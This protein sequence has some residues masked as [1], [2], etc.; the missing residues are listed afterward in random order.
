M[1]KLFRKNRQQWLVNNKFFKY[2]IYAIGEI[3]LV[4]IGILIA[5]QI[6]NWNGERKDLIKEQ[7]ILSQLKEE[8][9]ANL[10][11]LDEKMLMR[12]RIIQSSIEVLTYIDNPINT[13]FDSI[14]SKL[15]VIITD[16]TFDPIKNDLIISG[17]LR[18]IKNERLKRLLSNWSSDV[19]Q[20]Q[21]VE[22]EWQKMRTDMFVPFI[23]KLGISRDLTQDIWKNEDN[24]IYILDNETSSKLIIGKS[25]KTPKSQ[26]ILNNMELEGIVTNAITFNHVGNLQSI[27]L[28]NR[29][30]EILEILNKEI[31]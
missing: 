1:I 5:I 29:I 11:Q 22:I 28:R 14:I 2:L 26:E 13:N 7:Q 24:P 18:L 4:V 17:N 3:F 27:S 10:R 20:L 8:Y 6:N 16:P 31:K 9:E 23:I 12:S 15:G 19:L 25:K 30:L 21:E